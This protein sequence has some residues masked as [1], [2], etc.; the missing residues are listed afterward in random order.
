MEESYKNKKTILI[1]STDAT[2]TGTPILLLKQLRWLKNN[3]LYNYVLLLQSGGV[4]L[5]DFRQMG[6]VFLWDEIPLTNTSIIRGSNLW[7][8][9]ISRIKR[10]KTA[11]VRLTFVKSI[12]NK[13]CISLIFSNSARNGAILTELRKSFSCKILSYVHEGEKTLD[14]F[15]T[16]G[17]VTRSL[18]L[19]DKIL[20][21][22]DFIKKMLRERYQIS[23][24]ITVVPGAVQCCENVNSK[25]RE[26][27]LA[28]E[29]IPED[30]IIIMACGWLGWHK[31]T[32]FFIQIARIL[33]LLDTKLHFVWLGGNHLDEAYKQLIFDINKLN[34]AGRISIIESKQDSLDYL[35]L[36]EIFLVLSREESFSLV[37]VEAGLLRKP[38]LCFEKSGGPIEIINADKRFIVAY[39]DINEMA[40]RIISLVNDQEQRQAMGLYLHSRVRENYT[41]EVVGKSLLGEIDA[42]I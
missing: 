42:L 18:Q 10:K 1:I 40:N 23:N 3:S 15:N 17:F 21:V 26:T 38:V 29:N 5:D 36:A 37:T 27:I 7:V 16:E 32:D 4:L 20:A 41:I 13:Y 6:E 25:T 22:S 14:L 11:S 2:R 8:R 28:F 9:A 24:E 34:L 33:S 31:G 19:S 35:N 30:A 39:A 12:K